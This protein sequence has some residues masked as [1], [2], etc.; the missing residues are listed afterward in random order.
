MSVHNSDDLQRIYAARFQDNLEYRHAVWRVLVED[1]FQRRVRHTDAVLDLGSGYGEFISQIRCAQKWAM[2]LNPDTPKRV[3]PD[4]KCLLQDCSA[5]WELPDSLLDV[6][7]TSNFFEHLPDKG[8][9]GRTLDE[10]R[11]CLKTGGLIIAMGPN[12][13]YVCGA[14][15]D[16]WD[17]HLPLTD[18]SLTEALRLRGFEIERVIDRFLPYT[19]VN[20]RPAPPLLVYLYLKT[21]LAWRVLGKQFLIVARK[22]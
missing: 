12:I 2:D 22:P 1:F 8:A 17:H 21:P 9:L 6:V 13:K 5:R 14:Y 7:F 18:H 19:M 16:F 10:T 4:V 20:S 15:W 11:R 3:T